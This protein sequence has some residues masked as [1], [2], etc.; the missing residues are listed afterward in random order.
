MSRYDEK[1]FLVC[2]PPGDEQ[3][4]LKPNSQTAKRKYHYKKLNPGEA[5]LFFQNSYR[6]SDNNQWAITNVLVDMSGL[7]VSQAIYEDIRSYN[8][9]FM[10]TYPSVYVDDAGTYHEDYWYIGFFEKLNCLDVDNSTI[11]TFDFDEDDEDEDDEQRLEV[12]KYLLCDKMLDGIPEE[13]RLMFKL[14]GCSKKHIFVYHKIVDIFER[15]NAQGV[16]FF[17]VS[18]FKEGDQFRP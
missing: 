15:N 13:K 1:Y 16:R 5:P 3:I 6:E 2:L 18:E 12:E 9:N 17:K 7:L 8:I 4:C 10:Q 11:E 14:G